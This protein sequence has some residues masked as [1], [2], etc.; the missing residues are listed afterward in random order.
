MHEYF[1]IK[2]IE[3][4]QDRHSLNY[5][6]K[7]LEIA[8]KKYNYIIV[9]NSLH[10]NS[11]PSLRLRQYAQSFRQL[12]PGIAAIYKNLIV[13]L[14]TSDQDTF[15][16]Y[17]LE[18]FRKL[19]VRH[20]L[21]AGISNCFEDFS[22]SKKYFRQALEAISQGT[23]APFLADRIFFFSKLLP[24]RLMSTLPGYT[25]LEE[26]IAPCVQKLIKYDKEHKTDFTDTMNAY[27]QNVCN[28][29]KTAA[30]L[31]M[32]RNTL[33]YRIKKIEEITGTDFSSGEAL[34]N[35]L[36]SFKALELIKHGKS[37]E[38]E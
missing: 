2:L 17:A 5:R 29:T 16:D 27:V 11:V 10:E 32:H 13:I 20:N 1:L 35:I 18:S 38:V 26:C 28:V 7:L 24:Y 23:I 9:V 34:L 36:F 19:L 22:A 8:L 6:A 31:H 4:D 15:S 25:S 30:D 3:G 21:Y 37:T 33:V 12:F 14:Y